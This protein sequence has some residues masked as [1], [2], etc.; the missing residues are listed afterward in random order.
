MT[1]QLHTPH[2]PTPAQLSAQIG[3]R[4]SQQYPPLATPDGSPVK[5]A[6]FAN[7]GPPGIHCYN[8]SPSSSYGVSAPAS[9]AVSSVYTGSGYA[10]PLAA[11]TTYPTPVQSYYEHAPHHHHHHQAQQHQHVQQPQPS[12]QSHHH[13]QQDLW[14]K[15]PS[16]AM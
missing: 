7:A 13:H 1:H 12:H 16:V 10:V 5:S 11:A 3:R 15:R 6:P 4:P 2:Q 9:R 8:G 14:M